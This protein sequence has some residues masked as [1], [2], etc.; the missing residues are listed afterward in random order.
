MN[1]TIK[2]VEK[3][4]KQA[5]IEEYKK[6]A[7]IIVEEISGL[8]LEKLILLDKIEKE[9]EI[10]KLTQKRAD[11]KAPIQHLIGYTNFMGEKYIVNKDVLIPRDETEILVLEAYECIKNLKNKI[12]ILD[13][14]I[15]SGIISCALA[16]K[17]QNKE[18][19]ILGTDISFDAIRTALEN[20]N[21]LNLTRKIILRKSDIFSSIR[22]FEKF[23]LIV[24]NPPYIP[25]SEKENLQKEVKDFDP[26][27]A[28]F[29]NDK[30]GVEFYKKIIK[31][32]PNFLKK[33]GFLALECGIGQSCLIKDMLQNDFKNIKITKDLSNIDRVICAQIK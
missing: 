1:K 22:N 13:I 6:E 32:A 17:L 27:P 21:R 28:L 26:H 12:D 23:D 16:K 18:I 31:D 9:E 19:E 5:G 7:L 14:G 11:S 8:S 24:S 29:A 2:K 4:L 30:D 20:V 3:I 10:L 33:D 25:V 15:G